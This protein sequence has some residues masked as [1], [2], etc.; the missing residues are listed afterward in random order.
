MDRYIAVL[1]IVFFLGFI[2]LI[3]KVLVAME[4]HLLFKQGKVM[5]IRLAYIAITLIISYLLASSITGI[6][7]RLVTITYP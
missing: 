2:P 1:F 4:I 7:E 5:E 3:F 6:L